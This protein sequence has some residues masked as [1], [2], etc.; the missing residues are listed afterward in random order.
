MDH[1]EFDLSLLKSAMQIAEQKGWHRMTL[2]DAANRAD[3][4]ID[5]TR[6]RFPTKAHL[7][8]LLNAQ[9]DELALVDDGMTGSLKEKLFDILMRRFDVLQHYRGGILSLMRTLPFDPLLTAFSALCTFQSM[10]WMAQ[11]ANVDTSGLRGHVFVKALMG[12]W[13]YTIKVWSQDSSE[14][15]SKTMAA[16]DNALAKIV[17][18]PHTELHIAAL[19][20]PSPI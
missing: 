3:L 4:P 14:D 7:L 6:E 20:A 1:K 12:A 17:K 9:A 16:L 8:K 13:L 19:S 2:I 10:K 15:L 5:K 11:A 18:L